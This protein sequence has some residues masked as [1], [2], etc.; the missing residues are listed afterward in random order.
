MFGETVTIHRHPYNPPPL[1]VHVLSYTSLYR[2][3]RVRVLA[4]NLKVAGANPAHATNDFKGSG[5][6]PDPFLVGVS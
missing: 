5:E 4:H 1:Y 6:Q 3:S 2:M